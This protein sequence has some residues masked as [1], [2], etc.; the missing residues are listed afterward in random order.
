MT[1]TVWLCFRK[2]CE[3]AAVTQ[4]QVDCYR[5]TDEG[6]W[7][8]G[9]R[10]VLSGEALVAMARQCDAEDA[11][12]RDHV[13]R[14]RGIWET[15]GSH[16]CWISMRTEFTQPVVELG[17]VNTYVLYWFLYFYLHFYISGGRDRCI[18]TPMYLYQHVNL[19]CSSLPSK[20]LHL[21]LSGWVF[22]RLKWWADCGF[23][24]IKTV[25]LGAYLRGTTLTW[26]IRWNVLHP[27]DLFPISIKLRLDGCQGA[28]HCPMVICYVE[29]YFWS[30]NAIQFK[31]ETTATY[32]LISFASARLALTSCLSFLG[33]LRAT[34]SCCLLVS[35]QVKGSW[36][37]PILF[38]HFDCKYFR[39]EVGRMDELDCRI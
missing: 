12:G 33:L 39:L 14:T 7:G 4:D 21:L 22:C 26:H 31:T 32:M 13:T 17:T 36:L 35:L 24:G 1:N 25:L 38:Q 28:L 5:G 34:S 9:E 29:L 8:G 10:G 20:T 3:T 2:H 23:S 18:F 6:V 11:R 27:L 19:T 15:W 30:E 37:N 16:D